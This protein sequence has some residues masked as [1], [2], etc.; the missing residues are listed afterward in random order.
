MRLCRWNRA[1]AGAVKP[2]DAA[3][4]LKHRKEGKAINGDAKPKTA[5]EPGREACPPDSRTKS[6]HQNLSQ[7]ELWDGVCEERQDRGIE[8]HSIRQVLL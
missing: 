6:C 8:R 3:A 7:G 2:A 1:S 4:T 5:T